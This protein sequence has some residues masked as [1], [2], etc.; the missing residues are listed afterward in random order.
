M[1]SELSELLPYLTPRE[2]ERLD[3]LLLGN[4]AWSPNSEPQAL[5][6]HSQADI[7]FYGGA[8]GG[9]KTDL[10]LGLPRHEHYRSIIFRR[11][12]PSLAGIIER[13]ELVYAPDGVGRG[14]IYN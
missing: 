12:F 1:T 7:L 4:S 2:R 9:G 8:A 13:S 3:L 6:Y 11:I 5:A 10:L 14:A